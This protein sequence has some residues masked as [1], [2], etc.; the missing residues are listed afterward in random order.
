MRASNSNNLRKSR[1]PSS[2]GQSLS[3]GRATPALAEKAAP[4]QARPM[5]RIGLLGAGAM[6]ATHAAAYAGMPDVEVVG[7]LARTVERARSVALLCGALPFTDLATLIEA[8]DAVDVCL[9]TPRHRA[10]VVAT[11]R[12]G[13][14]V[15]CETPLALAMD[16]A[17]AMRDAAR[18]AGRLLQVGLLMRSIEAYAH[19]EEA[20]RSGEHGRLLSLSTWRLGSY[21]RPEAP[22]H[23]AHYGDP[24]TELMTFDF[25][26]ANWLM[27]KP[28]LLSAAGSGD[29][30]A[31]LSYDD[32]R[33]A[34]IRASGLM[35][36]A[37]PFTVG[38]RALFEGAV[39]T[40]ETVFSGGVSRSAFTICKGADPPRPFETAQ[41]NPYEVELRR[42][43]DCIAGK[44]DP[45][46]LDVDRAIE[47]LVLSL[48]TQRA[49]VERQSVA[50]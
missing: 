18:D 14:H 15:L 49:L 6:G 9:P 20:V 47:A 40:L 26:V 5:V 2:A 12:C 37:F 11:L 3:T 48:A 44:A 24:T 41:H 10:A 43:V 35:P 17:I 23:K 34:T 16:D 25:D 33:H 21:L 29:V 13:K 42:F 36:P 45:A 32:G 19:L 31:L 46:L 22:D 1:S 7:V 39:F 8:V 30:T 4:A 28:V 27:G 38:F 50:V